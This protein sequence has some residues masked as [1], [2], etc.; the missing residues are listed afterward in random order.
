MHQGPQR[1]RGKPCD[2]ELYAESQLFTLLLLADACRRAGAAHITAVMPYVGYARQDRRT[3]FR[4]PVAARLNAD[5]PR[6]SGLRR[7][8]AVDPHTAAM[9]GI[10]AMPLEHLSAVPCSRRRCARTVP[11]TASSS[12][13]ILGPPSWPI[14]CRDDARTGSEHRVR[15][16]GMQ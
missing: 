9:E 3:A 14:A 5:L 16:R 2:G 8:V 12:R 4:E 1:R 13:P 15:G 11:R 7:V 10:F 6:A